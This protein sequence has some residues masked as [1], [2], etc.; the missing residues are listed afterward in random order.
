MDTTIELAMSVHCPD[1]FL[2]K[3]TRCASSGLYF[4]DVALAARSKV[5]DPQQ[6]CNLLCPNHNVCT[7]QTNHNN[8]HTTQTNHTFLA[9]TA[10]NKEQFTKQ[11]VVAADA[12]Q[13]LYQNIGHPSQAK[14]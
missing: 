14:V 8:V 13:A 7:T 4:H 3:F 5:T 11:Q 2:M 6:I 10:K 12:A 9:T 1:R